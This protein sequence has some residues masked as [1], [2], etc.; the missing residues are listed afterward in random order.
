M[1]DTITGKYVATSATIRWIQGTVF[2]MHRNGESD[3][4]Y[5]PF[6]EKMQR[7]FGQEVV[8]RAMK[9]AQLERNRR[10][11]AAFIAENGSIITSM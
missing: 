1:K 2:H 3:K 5:A 11:A 4:Y 8:D 7:F 10:A 9:P 6:M